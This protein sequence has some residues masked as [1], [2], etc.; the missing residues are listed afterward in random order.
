MSFAFGVVVG[1]L[2]ALTVF[3]CLFFWAS[4]Y[5]DAYE[6]ARDEE[7]AERIAEEAFAQ[8]RAERE[9]PVNPS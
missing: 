1:G 3:A 2:L 6:A 9:L 8:W 5:I 4:R 7:D